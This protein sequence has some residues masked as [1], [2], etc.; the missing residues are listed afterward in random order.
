[1]LFS[2]VRI[3]VGFVLAVLVRG[4]GGAGGPGPAW[5]GLLPR[6]LMVTVKSIPVASFII[7][8]LL[9]AEHGNLA[10][11]ISFLMVLPLCTQH[12]HRHPSGRRTALELARLYRVPWGRAIVIRLPGAAAFPA[13]LAPWGWVCAGK[14]AWPPK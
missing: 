3:F 14:A 5:C 11:F 1:M 8:A 9:A 12:A 2:T 10:V 6:P 4:A 13:R 7:L